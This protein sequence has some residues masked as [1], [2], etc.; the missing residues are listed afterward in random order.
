MN[1]ARKGVGCCCSSFLIFG[2]GS[3][4][5]HVECYVGRSMVRGKITTLRYQIY[6]FYHETLISDSECAR[7][8]TRNPVTTDKC[9]VRD[10]IATNLPQLPFLGVFRGLW[11]TLFREGMKGCFIAISHA[12]MKGCFI[13]ISYMGM[14]GCFITISYAGVKG[15]FIILFIGNV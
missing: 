14:K 15:C 13:T 2:V 11:L 7:G 1:M 9:Q 6:K 3:N 12:G 8:A 10:T 5:S 4:W